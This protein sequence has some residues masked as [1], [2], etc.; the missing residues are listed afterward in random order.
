MSEEAII[1][2]YRPS[3][4]SKDMENKEACRI[5]AERGYDLATCERSAVFSLSW[6]IML[7]KLIQQIAEAAF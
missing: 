7:F 4:P 1:Y 5:L 3:M 2:M 6:F